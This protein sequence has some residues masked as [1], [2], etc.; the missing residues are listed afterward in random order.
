MVNSCFLSATW[1][2][3]PFPFDFTVS[4]SQLSILLL[5]LWRQKVPTLPALTAF[6]LF[7]CFDFQK[8]H[9]VV[10]RWSFFIQTLLGVLGLLDSVALCHLFVLENS[11][12]FFSPNYFSC[13]IFSLPTYWNSNYLYMRPFYYISQ[14]FQITFHYFASLCFIW[15]FSFALYSSSLTLSSTTSG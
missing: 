12:S 1:R 10:P 3:H 5:L 14:I 9:C 11:Q 8:S 7:S 13:S 2:Y 4:V 15:V 6:Q